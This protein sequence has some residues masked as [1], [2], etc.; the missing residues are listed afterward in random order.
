MTDVTESAAVPADALAAIE[1][2]AA[3]NLDALFDRTHLG[4]R[5]ALA[6]RQRL[7]EALAGGGSEGARRVETPAASG[8]S[9]ASPLWG[10]AHEPD[11]PAGPSAAAL[12]A[13][14]E[15]HEA[16]HHEALLDRAH[17]GHKAALAARQ[18]LYEALR[19]A[20]PPVP[21]VGF[22][23]VPETAAGYQLPAFE[24]VDGVAPEIHEAGVAIAREA[25]HA[26]QLAH[27]EAA[28][29]ADRLARLPQ[30]GPA[31]PDAEW[32]KL[33]AEFGGD[34]QAEAVCKTVG[35]FLRRHVPAH[36]AQAFVERGA[37]DDYV[38]LRYLYKA[39][40]R[41]ETKGK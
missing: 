1:R 33:V 22:A 8:P 31:S 36:V 19:D 34:E 18:R 28:L 7:F 30:N 11:R 37:M 13:L 38:I 32:R 14:I 21:E 23:D 40:Q 15:R 5:A 3:E 20:S 25:A 41:R 27:G 24:P 6:E 12:R 2:H 26:L 16:D 17:P 29:I 10:A 35:Q 4:H 9:P 39:A